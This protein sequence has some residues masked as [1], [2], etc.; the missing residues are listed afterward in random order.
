MEG[1]IRQQSFT[2]RQRAY[3]KAFDGGQVYTP[4]MVLNG[5]A[6]SSRYSLSD[7]QSFALGPQQPVVEIEAD[8]DN[9]LARV[10]SEDSGHF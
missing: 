6:H 3:G 9:L 7:I 10:K 8:G 2:D 4:Q 1:H 5:A